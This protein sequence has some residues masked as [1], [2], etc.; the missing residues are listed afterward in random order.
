MAIMTEPDAV[1]RLLR[2]ITDFLKSWHKLQKEAIPSIDGML[3]LDDIV[4]FIGEDQFL[5]FAF[6]YFK[7]LYDTNHRIKFFHNDAECRMSVKHYPGLGINLYNPGLDMGLNEIIES[8]GHQL[9]I[10]GNIPPRDV[11]AAGSPE[12]VKKAVKEMLSGVTDK[13]R[14]IPSCGGGMPPHVRTEN[15]NAFLEAIHEG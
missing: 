2:L 10:L 14:L 1:H 11:L 6:P 13:S 7:E 3:M 12:N 9:T 8:T 15:I 5:E 4:G